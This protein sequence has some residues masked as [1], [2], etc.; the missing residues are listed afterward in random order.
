M[1]E[2]AKK[3]P[4]TSCS[5][6]AAAARVIKIQEFSF[7][8]KNYDMTCQSELKYLSRAYNSYIRTQLWPNKEI[9]RT[10]D[11]GVCMHACMHAVVAVCC[12]PG[13]GKNSNP[14]DIYISLMLIDETHLFRIM[15]KSPMSLGK[16][17]PVHLGLTF[18][19]MSG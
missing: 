10:K 17:G 3:E 15:T 6:A 4:L 12:M 19:Y 16:I 5:A 9:Y 1:Q 2:Q 18:Y 7:S 11:V 13:G 8:P 14:V